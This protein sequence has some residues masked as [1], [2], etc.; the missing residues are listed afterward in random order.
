LGA[1]P[2]QA[3]KQ[4]VRVAIRTGM[5]P[6]IDSLKTLGIVQLP[7]MM[8][9]LILAGTSPLEAIKYQLMVMFMLSAAVS[10]SCMFLG[11]LLGRK[12]FN[13]ALQLQI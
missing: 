7:G 5:I 11:L 9:G 12:F 4:A 1:T 13:S 10:I 2:A 6:T 8:T 3:A